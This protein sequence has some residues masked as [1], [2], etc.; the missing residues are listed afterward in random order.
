MQSLTARTM[1]LALALVPKLLPVQPCTCQAFALWLEC[2][3][4][5]LPQHADAH[6]LGCYPCALLFLVQWLTLRMCVISM[7]FRSSALEAWS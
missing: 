6:S 3:A 5:R 7:T 4:P 1:L 2:L